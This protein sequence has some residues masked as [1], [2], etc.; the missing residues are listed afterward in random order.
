[1]N[2]RHR[3]CGTPNSAALSSQCVTVYPSLFKPETTRSKK[4]PPSVSSMPRTFSKMA[5]SGCSDVTW[6]RNAEKSQFDGLSKFLVRWLE[7]ENPLQGGPPKTTTQ[8]FLR[9]SIS[10]GLRLARSAVT[11]L[12]PGWLARNVVT[13]LGFKSIATFTETS[14]HVAPSDIPPAP[15]KRSTPIICSGM[16]CAPSEQTFYRFFSARYARPASSGKNS[17]EGKRKN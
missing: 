11:A 15:E 7:A 8:S 10:M 13:A 2:T 9:R 17:T 1:M 6:R 16:N 4:N 14:A 12:T 5:Q 3:L